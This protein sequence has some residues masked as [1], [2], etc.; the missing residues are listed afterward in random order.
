M[1][2]NNIPY[3][4]FKE[5]IFKGLCRLMTFSAILILGVLLYHIVSEGWERLSSDFFNNLPS[6]RPSQ[7]GIKPALWGTIWLMGLTALFAIPLA[8]AS[9]LY[10]EEYAKKNKLNYW[11][12]INIANLAGVPSIV[13]G[14]LGLL[15]FVRVLALGNS[16]LAGALTL[17]LLILPVIITSAR[18]AIRAVPR[19]LRQASLALGASQWQT[20]WF[21][22]LPA[23]LP[24][25]LTGVILSLSRAIGETAPLIMVGAAMYIANV[26]EGPMDSYSALPMQIYDW[27]SRPQVEFHELAAAAIMALLGIL[28]FMNGIAV[29]IRQH[30]QVKGK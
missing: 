29:W 27:S 26:P 1:S 14:M 13:Y 8:V 12:D 9:A 17:T 24:G 6:R 22:V 30:Y 4:R 19:G 5:K 16:L 21:H 15:F 7:A 20:I 11:I 10:L 2:G 3:R 18:E 23:S 25:I 28:L